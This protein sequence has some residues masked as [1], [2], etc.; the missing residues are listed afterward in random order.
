MFSPWSSSIAS[1]DPE[2]QRLSQLAE[3]EDSS[4]R[5]G[6]AFSC[7]IVLS[8]QLL[9]PLDL[10]LNNFGLTPTPTHPSLEHGNLFMLG[11]ET[12]FH[13]LQ[14]CHQSIDDVPLFEIPDPTLQ[15]RNRIQLYTSDPRGIEVKVL[16][17]IVL[18]VDQFVDLMTIQLDFTQLSPGY[19][20]GLLYLLTQRLDLVSTHV[21]LISYGANRS[22]HCL[23]ALVDDVEVVSEFVQLP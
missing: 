21:E 7:N 6:R 13:C 23:V 5:T 8:V 1:A 16:P 19:V 15:W 18:R 4:P 20:V 11:D 17:K 9:N 12:I 14:S 22:L 2:R 10:L 3:R